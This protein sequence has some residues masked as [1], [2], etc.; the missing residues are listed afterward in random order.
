MLIR[1]K[2]TDGS[3]IIRLL[4]SKAKVAPLKTISI[5]RLELC[6]AEMAALLHVDTDYIAK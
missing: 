5:P 1:S 4:T 3:Y 2:S 6:A